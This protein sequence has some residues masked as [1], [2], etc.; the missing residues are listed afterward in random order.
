MAELTPHTHTRTQVTVTVSMALETAMPV[1]RSTT[2]VQTKISRQPLDGLPSSDIS[3]SAIRRLTF[4]ILRGISQKLLA[5][6]P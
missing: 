3:S 2:L 6:L 4:M 5:G 1:S